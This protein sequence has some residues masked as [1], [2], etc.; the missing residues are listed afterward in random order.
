MPAD[1]NVLKP[2]GH[3]ATPRT[4]PHP[5]GSKIHLVY[6]ALSVNLAD[7]VKALSSNPLGLAVVLAFA[8]VLASIITQA[9]EFEAIRLL[10]GYL[11]T[12]ASLPQALIG[13][14]IR[15]HLGSKHSL[16]LRS[17]RCMASLSTL[18]ERHGVSVVA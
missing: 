16:G 17:V 13:L 11:D 7:A 6:V 2:A 8:L 3:A 14:R 10:E 5:T 12:E 18:C 15:R 9:F 1:Q 4:S